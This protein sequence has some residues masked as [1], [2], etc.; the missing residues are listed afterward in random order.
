MNG[1]PEAVVS[2][3]SYHV[4]TTDPGTLV[5]S[6]DNVQTGIYMPWPDVVDIAL[7]AMEAG[8]A[9]DANATEDYQELISLEA[10]AGKTYFYRLSTEYKFGITPNAVLEAVDEKEAVRELQNLRLAGKPESYV[11]TVRPN[12]IQTASPLDL[13]EPCT[14]LLFTNPPTLTATP[15]RIIF[16]R[17]PSIRGRFCIPPIRSRLA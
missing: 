10:A 11:N 14:P 5:L 16:D 13:A 1:T 15:S 7:I 12:T 17:T 6:A 4:I 9:A 2:T 8:R 3:D